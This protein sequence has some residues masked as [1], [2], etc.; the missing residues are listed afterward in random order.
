MNTEVSTGAM[1]LVSVLY[2]V[3]A[4]VTVAALVRRGRG[5][6]REPTAP[7]DRQLTFAVAFFFVIPV[8]VLL[9][10]LA[11]AFATRSVG[12]QVEQLTWR[13]YW[14]FVVPSGDFAPLESWWI[15]LAGNLVGFLFGVALLSVAP[16][17]GRGRPSLGRVLLVAGQLEILFTLIVY[18]LLTLGGFFASD[19]KTIY[20]FE[21]T[22]VASGFTAAVHASLLV[23]LWLSRERL[24]E[25]D[26]AISSGQLDELARLRTAI[27]RDPADAAARHALARLY[28]DGG[29][30]ARA[31]ETAAD[32]LKTCG[33]HVAL[34]AVLAEALA[35]RRQY[36][37]ALGPIARGI[38]LSDQSTD[39]AKYL[40]AYRAMALFGSGRVS[41]ALDAFSALEEPAASD[42][43]IVAWHERAR[44]QAQ[45]GGMP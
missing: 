29:S 44:L 7:R 32:G 45:A 25:V 22:P 6:W 38:E 34:Y 40:H 2:G 30:P 10:E 17:W 15:S 1:D 23:A 27:A 16:R 26:L 33:E 35:Q 4:F 21:A 36:H 11:H 43:G 14:G 8:G 9:H 18:P 12:G 31:A 41:E 3:C 20:D 13:V 19:W 39:T 5:F 24:R 42:P 37:E 28:L